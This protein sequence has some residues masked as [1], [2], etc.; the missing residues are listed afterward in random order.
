MQ[1]CEMGIAELRFQQAKVPESSGVH[2][3]GT[4]QFVLN[5]VFVLNT[6]CIQTECEA[7]FRGGAIAY[8]A[9]AKTQV[10]KYAN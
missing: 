10:N 2:T 1:N 7:N 5:I 8:K 3:V 9:N 4:F 6:P